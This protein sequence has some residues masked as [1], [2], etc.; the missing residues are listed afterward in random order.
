VNVE[1]ESS[2]GIGKFD[3]LRAMI[4]AGRQRMSETIAKTTKRKN[5]VWLVHAKMRAKDNRREVEAFSQQMVGWICPG[6]VGRGKAEWGN[7]RS[8]RRLGQ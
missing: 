7:I 4:K 5:V 2:T 8:E 1:E 3:Q 6:D